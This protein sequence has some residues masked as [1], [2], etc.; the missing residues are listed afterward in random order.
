MNLVRDIMIKDPTICTA[1]TS[2]DNIKKIMSDTGREEILIVDTLV[3]AHLVGKINGN[4]ISRI[5]TEKSVLPS[6][7]NAEQCLTPVG[8]VIGQNVSAEEC[9]QLMNEK[10]ISRIP[11][12]DEQGHCCGIVDKDNLGGENASSS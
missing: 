7:L 1:T 9:L 6:Q 10:H 3:E 12:I 4:T 5:S 8:A 11:V 2:I